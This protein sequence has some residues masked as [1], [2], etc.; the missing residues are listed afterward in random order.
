MLKISGTRQHLNP[1]NF[2]VLHPKSACIKISRPFFFWRGAKEISYFIEFYFP[3]RLSF[4]GERSRNDST[5]KFLWFSS[6]F[7]YDEDNFVSGNDAGG[8]ERKSKLI[9]RDLKQKKLRRKFILMRWEK[10][11]F[12]EN[13]NLIFWE[14]F[15][16]IFPKNFL[17]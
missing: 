9:S 8:A 11:K 2:I 14:F 12:L 16:T 17:F 15:S 6:W 5:Q 4:S 1:L 7:F 10:K 13:G 3:M